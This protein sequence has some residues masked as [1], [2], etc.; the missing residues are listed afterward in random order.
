MSGDR[1]WRN[2]YRGETGHEDSDLL[3][4]NKSTDSA[5]ASAA[6]R[7]DHD[8]LWT[9][10]QVAT[11]FTGIDAPTSLNL[12][13]V[14]VGGQSAFVEYISPGQINAQVPG[15]IGLGSQPVIVSTPAGASAAYNIT[16]TLQ[17]PGLYAPTVFRSVGNQ[18]VGA[19][20]TN[21]TTYVFPTGSFAGIPSRS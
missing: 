1:Q 14:S 21:G 5:M 19:L 6:G 18:Y 12:T 7:L 11:D 20:F 4:R 15:T 2:P 13:T 17:K 9:P 16:A 3:P 10:E 8:P